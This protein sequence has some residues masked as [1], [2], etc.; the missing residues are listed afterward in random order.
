MTGE[1]EVFLRK[2]ERAAERATQADTSELEDG[3]HG[4]TVPPIGRTVFGIGPGKWDSGALA[5]E[6]ETR[7]KVHSDARVYTLY[8]EFVSGLPALVSRHFAG[9]TVVTGFGICCDGRIE[10]AAVITIVGAAGELDRVAT[11]A[12][13]INRTN[14]QTETIITW[15]DAQSVIVK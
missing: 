2:M 12:A 6:Q 15:H 14:V 9:A 10:R 1:L 4:A 13:D 5:R 7:A 3:N 8:T 11:L